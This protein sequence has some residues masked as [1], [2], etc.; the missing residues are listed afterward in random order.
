M[1]K[2]KYLS[3]YKTRK[4]VDKQI[5]HISIYLRAYQRAVGNLQFSVGLGCTPMN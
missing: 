1:A 5:L 2:D 4:P 3:F